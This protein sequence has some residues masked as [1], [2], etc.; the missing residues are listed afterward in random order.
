VEHDIDEL[1]AQAPEA[2]D[3]YFPGHW[4]LMRELERCA[5]Q[6]VANKDLDAFVSF[7]ERSHF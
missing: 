4:Q 7:Y 3:S 6:V 5:Q 2:V 1:L